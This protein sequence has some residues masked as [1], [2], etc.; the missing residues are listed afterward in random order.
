MKKYYLIKS[1]A[2]L[3]VVV[4]SIKKSELLR[5]L[6]QQKYH[7]ISPYTAQLIIIGR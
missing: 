7:A 1:L 6:L 4:E 5:I 2:K 3:V